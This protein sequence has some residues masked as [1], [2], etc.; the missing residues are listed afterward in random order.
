MTKNEY[1]AATHNVN[2]SHKVYVSHS[3]E[4]KR[5]DTEEIQC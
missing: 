1:P 4:Q 5:P 2:E 3:A